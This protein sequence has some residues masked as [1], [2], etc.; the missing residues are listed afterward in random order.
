MFQT[1]AKRLGASRL[2][3]LY[4][5]ETFTT[6]EGAKRLQV[7]APLKE[8]ALGLLRFYIRWWLKGKGLEKNDLPQK[9]EEEGILDPV[10]DVKSDEKT[11][12]QTIFRALWFSLNFLGQFPA[13]R[14]ILREIVTN[15][16]AG[17]PC[18]DAHDL[19]LQRRA[20][21]LLYDNAGLAPFL[22]KGCRSS[23]LYYLDLKRG[24]STKELQEIRTA[25]AQPS[26]VAF[27]DDYFDLQGW[28]S[29]AMG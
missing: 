15:N 19:W 7:I 23:L 24:L 4:E 2:V 10:E 18:F 21:L 12:F 14:N 9:L 27:H 3:L 20:A 5:K 29:L 16:P 11:A 26:E 22:E 28:L 13:S 8:D 25:V 17:I 6:S 1:S